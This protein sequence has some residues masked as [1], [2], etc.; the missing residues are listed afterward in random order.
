MIFLLD[1]DNVLL[2]PSFLPC[3]FF[4]GIRAMADDLNE[5]GQEEEE[6]VMNTNDNHHLVPD[7]YMNDHGVR[8]PHVGPG[9][10]FF[11][12]HTLE[13][14]LEKYPPIAKEGRHSGHRI[15]ALAYACFNGFPAAIIQ[16]IMKERPDEL[17]Y[18]YNGF[19]GTALTC[20]LING[21]MEIL[22]VLLSNP[23]VDVNCG[24]YYAWCFDD[25]KHPCNEQSC[26]PLGHMCAHGNS[27]DM[28]F[29]LINCLPILFSM[30]GH[31]INLERVEEH[32]KK[33]DN[34]SLRMRPSELARQRE[35]KGLATQLEELRS[36]KRIYEMFAL[37]VMYAD[38]YYQQQTKVAVLEPLFGFMPHHP[39]HNRLRFLN[40][41][42]KLP[43]ELQL[44]VCASAEGQKDKWDSVRIERGF[45]AWAYYEKITPSP[46][47]MKDDDNE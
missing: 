13:D 6:E 15:S 19:C 38:E 17:N 3:V 34:N 33:S 42:R 4:F 5:V 21:Y 46:L 24:G 12:H 39:D 35:Y 16:E 43:M 29:H 28:E 31:Q 9:F 25:I 11:M 2:P 18:P 14:V 26:T 37:L 36:Q 30:R 27:P 44:N 45:M 22:K 1:I 47:P 41:C 7:Y 23:E 32:S 8:C 10:F 40:I 20:C